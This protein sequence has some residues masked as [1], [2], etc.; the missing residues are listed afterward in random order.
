MSYRLNDAD[1]NRSTEA[2]LQNIHERTRD[3][4]NFQPAFERDIIDRHQTWAKVRDNGVDNTGRPILDDRLVTGAA[5]WWVEAGRHP[6]F[7]VEAMVHWTFSPKTGRRHHFTSFK[8]NKLRRAEAEG[9]YIVVL[10]ERFYHIV[11]PRAA[12]WM[13]DN[14]WLKPM[15]HMGNKMGI[16]LSPYDV[17]VLSQ[18]GVLVNRVWMPAA[19]KIVDY[20]AAERF[21]NVFGPNGPMES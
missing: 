1:G 21:L 17:E 3:E 11:T 12:G 6:G 15:P 9:V 5:D 4:A 16:A 8:E 13:L 18:S 14:M 7:L 10:R 19:Q 2:G 20:C